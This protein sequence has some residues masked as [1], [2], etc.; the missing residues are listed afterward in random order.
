MLTL[1]IGV[2]WADEMT[3][4]P[5]T[6]T[7]ASVSGAPSGVTC[8]FN[9][10]YSQPTQVTAGNTMTFTVKN[11]PSGYTITGVTL[12]VKTNAK[13]G[14]GTVSVT[15]GTTIGSLSIS[16]LGNSYQLKPVTITPVTTVGS[17]NLVI[18]ISASENSVYCEQVTIT[19]EK[20]GSTSTCSAPTFSPAAGTY[21]SAQNVTIACATDGATIY[22]TTDGSD[23]TT[24]SSVYS[25][26][27]PVS[28]TTTIKA[29]AA[30][31]GYNNSPVA[32]ATYTVNEIPEGSEY[33]LV[34]DVSV[35][36]NGDQIV[37]MSEGSGSGFAMSTTQKEN[38]RPQTTDALNI[39][40][41][42]KYR[43]SD[44]HS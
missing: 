38:Y 11:I 3:L 14:A 36:S 9:N 20:G 43:Y 34:T 39:Q 19:Y 33:T 17:K 8:E 7:S 29:M 35:L 16:T 2:G 42:S 28:S 13:S 18:S 1:A 15:Y 22:Y 30:L 26:A 5:I 27:I 41:Y 23:P 10:T 21:T 32:E 37:F 31:S 40:D 24:N 6:I 44:Y 4:K 12:S 25:A